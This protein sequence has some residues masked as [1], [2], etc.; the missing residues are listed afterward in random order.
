[1]NWDFFIIIFF[2]FFCN[3]DSLCFSSI[4]VPSKSTNKGCKYC[5]CFHSVATFCALFSVLP[6]LASSSMW[7][8]IAGASLQGRQYCNKRISICTIISWK[9]ELA[10]LLMLQ[11][12]HTETQ[13]QRPRVFN[14]A[15]IFFSKT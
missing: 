12:S 3:S 15:V 2:F 14:S 6:L 4:V 8:F 1:M 5:G 11:V 10:Q 9:L 7:E 13:S